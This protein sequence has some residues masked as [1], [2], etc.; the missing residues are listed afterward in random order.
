[1]VYLLLLVLAACGGAEQGRGGTTGDVGAEERAACGGFERRPLASA[2]VSLLA[3]HLTMRPLEGLEVVARPRAIMAAPDP[4]A[5]ETRLSAAVDEHRKLTVIAN[6]PFRRPG[7]D[8]ASSVAAW[9]AAEGED[10]DVRPIDTRAPLRAVLAVPRTVDS[11]SE[12]VL[13]ARV[14]VASPDDTAQHLGVFI[15]SDVAVE[16]HEGCVELAIEMA[17]TLAPGDRRVEAS[18]GRA[19]LARGL[20]IEVAPGWVVLSQPGPDFD[21]A[22]ITHLVELGG[23]HSGL[24][25]YVGGHPNPHSN[26]AIDLS[27]ER[28]TLFG[29]DVSWRAWTTP[30]QVGRDVHREVI[31]PMPGRAGLS[32]HAFMV[33]EDPEMVAV[34]KAMT[35]SLRS[36]AAAPSTST[37]TSTTGE[38]E[39]GTE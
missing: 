1:M 25:I 11:V 26:E 21:V 3:G 4:E 18:G 6:E 8:L 39:G 14:I 34:M 22:W 16:G 19:E 24:G 36:G 10:V 12:A 30:G 28:G 29:N 2:P 13:V 15:T 17:R 5:W 27:E 37:S 32:V 35:E 9:L 38:A 31:A 7:E 20:T 23:A 33:S